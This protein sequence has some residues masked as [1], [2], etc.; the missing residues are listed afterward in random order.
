[1]RYFKDQPLVVSWERYVLGFIRYE[2]LNA[3]AFYAT[4]HV[5]KNLASTS[6]PGDLENIAYNNPFFDING[7]LDKYR[8]VLD[9]ASLIIDYLEKRGLE[10]SVYIL[11]SGEGAHVRINEKAFSREILSKYNSLN[12]AYS[13]V[14]IADASRYSIANVIQAWLIP[15][16]IL[17]P[18]F[19]IYPGSRVVE[20]AG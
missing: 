12:I 8:S 16:V 11:W 6:M 19:K 17:V 18:M 15:R 9:V 1:V 4:I 10:E 3:R 13:I 7:S 2:R 14:G 5:Y 20:E